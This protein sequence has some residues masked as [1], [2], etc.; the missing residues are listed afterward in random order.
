MYKNWT[1]ISWGKGGGCQTKSLPWGGVWIFSGTAHLKFKLG[2]A[3]KIQLIFTS[4]WSV[5]LK[6]FEL[7]VHKGISRGRGAGILLREVEMPEMQSTWLDISQSTFLCV[8]CTMNPQGDSPSPHRYWH[9]P[10]LDSPLVC[11]QCGERWGHKPTFSS[12]QKRLC[13]VTWH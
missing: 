7:I 10:F 4:F 8:T 11:G 12:V 5:M 2:F 9:P 13:L 1:A 3:V 6:S